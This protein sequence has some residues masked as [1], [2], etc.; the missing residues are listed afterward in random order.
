MVDRYIVYGR[1]TCFFC[2]SA[3]SLLEA[4][5]L[6]HVFMDLT[7]DDQA[8]TEAR[9]FYDHPTVPIILKNNQNDGL[10]RLIGGYTELA[11]HLGATDF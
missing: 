1:T 10:T 9:I 6:E 8:L 2:K 3:L 5:D 4:Q 7:G 11:E